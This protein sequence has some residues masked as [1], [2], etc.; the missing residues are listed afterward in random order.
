MDAPPLPADETAL[1]HRAGI[2]DPPPPEEG[3]FRAGCWLRRV[4]AETAILVGGGRALLL[5]I[6]HPLVAQGVAEHSNFR[7]DPFGRLQRTLDALGAITFGD[8]RAAL[9][10]A[11]AVEKAHARVR[12]RLPRAAGPFAAGTPYSGR[13]PEL[14]RWV[15]ATLVDTALAVYRRFVA[16]LDAAALESYY[17]DQCSVARLLG[18]PAGLVPPDFAAFDRYFET[19]LDSDALTVT[20]T[21]REIAEAVLAVPGGGRVRLVTAGLLPPHLREAFGLAWDAGRA[22]RLASLT[23]SVRALRPALDGDRHAR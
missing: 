6:A 15:W 9:A 17:T 7:A 12:G 8:R 20:P 23:A 2:A 10:A 21:A 16:P 19:M 22:A 1:L 14:M 3:L 4:G 11:F 5:E 18:I 13:D